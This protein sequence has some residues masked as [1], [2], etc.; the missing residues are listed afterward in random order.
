MESAGEP[1]WEMEAFGDGGAS[2]QSEELLPSEGQ[3]L[4]GHA[5][6]KSSPCPGSLYVFW[7]TSTT[8]TRPRL[9]VSP[10]WT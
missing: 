8:V 6:R 9:W 5:M 4:W 10:T 7:G 3:M 1:A 2:G